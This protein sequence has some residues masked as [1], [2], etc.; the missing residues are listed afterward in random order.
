VRFPAR[1]KCNFAVRVSGCC[2]EWTEYMSTKQQLCVVQRETT[3]TNTHGGEEW[4]GHRMV[5]RQEAP[6]ISATTAR[7]LPRRVAIG[8]MPGRLATKVFT[9]PTRIDNSD[10]SWED[11]PVGASESA[12]AGS[13]TPAP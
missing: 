13:E 10:A 3:K 8:F 6:I 9:S 7:N 4:E 5:G 12:P 1:D 2:A 11:K